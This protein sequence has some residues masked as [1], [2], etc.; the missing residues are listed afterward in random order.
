LKNIHLIFL[1]I[2][3]CFSGELSAYPFTIRPYSGD[4]KLNPEYCNT[5]GQ[6]DSNTKATVYGDSRMDYMGNIPGLPLYD[7]DL[8]SRATDFLFPAFAVP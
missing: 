4:D 7:M 5:A 8:R 6:Y 1:S 3:L 2:S